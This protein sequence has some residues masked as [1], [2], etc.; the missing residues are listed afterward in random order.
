M[1]PSAHRRPCRPHK[2]AVE[3]ERASGERRCS[4]PGADV[5]P[6]SLRRND[7]RVVEMLTSSHPTAWC[8]RWCSSAASREQDSPCPAQRM[9]GRLPRPLHVGD[10]IANGAP[11]RV[12]A[13]AGVVILAFAGPVSR[14][15][16]VSARRTLVARG[17]GRVW[18]RRTSGSPRWRRDTARSTEWWRRGTRLP[19][20]KRPDPP[21]CGIATDAGR[22]AHGPRATGDAPSRRRR[23]ARRAARGAP[24]RPSRR[25]R[26]QAARRR[27]MV[28]A[29][30]RR[31]ARAL[32]RRR[33]RRPALVATPPGRCQW[34]GGCPAALSCSG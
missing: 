20:P 18:T 26:Q 6:H 27:R 2:T 1:G 5:P 24:I 3:G 10:N 15:V 23:L 16:T 34:M 33:P 8:T 7:I 31:T 32:C 30:H 14:A 13:N 25:R 9:R 4:G 21:A 22:R 17:R 29:T 19:S 11:A 28:R 12:A